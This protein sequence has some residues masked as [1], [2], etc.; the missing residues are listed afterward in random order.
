MKKLIVVISIALCFNTYIFSEISEILRNQKE[1]LTLEM[2]KDEYLFS[3]Y[4]ENGYLNIGYESSGFIPTIL[5]Y[6][7]KNNIIELIVKSRWCGA[8]VTEPNEIYRSYYYLVELLEN[9]GE[10]QTKVSR[11]DKIKFSSFIIYDGILN[12][13]NVNIRTEPS[14]KSSVIDRLNKGNKVHINNTNEER[15]SINNLVDYW[16]Y[17]NNQKPGWI[18]G[19]YVD[20]AKKI[21]I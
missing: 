11:I 19:Y 21:K 10:L 7:K 14:I 17:I 20:F 6:S 1:W 18:F 4:I 5:G 8:E 12:D 15:I 16:Y 3:M 2:K 13:N 9:N